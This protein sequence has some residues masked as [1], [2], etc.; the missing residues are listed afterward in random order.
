MN[1][2]TRNHIKTSLTTVMVIYCLF[3]LNT[4]YFNLAIVIHCFKKNCNSFMR[5]CLSCYSAMPSWSD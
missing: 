4:V 2:L 3:L 5:R 1:S